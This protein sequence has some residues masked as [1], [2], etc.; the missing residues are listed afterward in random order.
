MLKVNT[1]D[2]RARCMCLLS[3]EIHTE[4]FH[5]SLDRYPYQYWYDVCLKLGRGTEALVVPLLP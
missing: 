3:A 2:T 4:S 5:I 1:R